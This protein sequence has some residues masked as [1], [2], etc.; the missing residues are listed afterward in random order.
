MAMEEKLE[1]E[2]A[3]KVVASGDAVLLDIRGDEEW[4]EKRIAG[5]HRASE[6]DMDS[7]LEELDSDQAV[8][9]VCDDGERSAKVAGQLRED[10]RD[11]A[12]IDGG[13]DAWAK[14][15]PT[16]PSEDPADDAQV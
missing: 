5:A 4:H 16:Q 9:I 8:V 15:F 13:M 2:E 6:E 11:A 3:R 12:S 7:A 10:G 14:D 1:P